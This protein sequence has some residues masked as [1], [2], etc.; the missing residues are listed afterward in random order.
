MIHVNSSLAMNQ[1]AQST[2][3]IQMGYEYIKGRKGMMY[4]DSI[5]QDHVYSYGYLFRTV[6]G[7]SLGGGDGSN[8]DHIR[9]THSRPYVSAIVLGVWTL[10]I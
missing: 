6:H 7:R 3:I 9:S 5:Y 4:A 10:W 8:D 2:L 1:A